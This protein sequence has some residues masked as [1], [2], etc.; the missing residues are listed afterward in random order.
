[1]TRAAESCAGVIA[2]LRGASAGLV[3]V[4]AIAGGAALGFAHDLIP[5][6][7]REEPNTTFESLIGDVCSPCVKD[8]YAVSTLP[9]APLKPAGF[10]PAVTNMMS[11]GG[12]VRL[13][14]VRAYPLDKLSQKFLAMRATLSI[15]TGDGQFLPVAIGLV[16][17]D[18]VTTF[19]AAVDKIA[20]SAARRPAEEPVPD[21]R[22][23]DVHAGSLRIGVLRIRGGEV[24]YLQAGNVRVLRA[25]T[26]FETSSALFF[27]VADLAALH[28]AIG[29]AEIKIKKLRG[30]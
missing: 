13:E 19:A 17:E 18:E 30:Q 7:T 28:D 24:A 16:D 29:Q 14:V 20:K 8:S 26:P 23:M 12:E 3:L 11:R 21:T 6:Q 5:G 27:P 22:E 4:G 15:K 10:G 25:P 2:I 1:M 9:L